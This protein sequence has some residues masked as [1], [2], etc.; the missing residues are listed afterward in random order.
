MLLGAGHD[1]GGRCGCGSL[2][3]I[4]LDVFQRGDH[5]EPGIFKIAFINF[6]DV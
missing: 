6:L 5:I 4:A 2:L 3:G 1:S